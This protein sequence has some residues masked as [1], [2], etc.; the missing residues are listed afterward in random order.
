M[1]LSGRFISV[2]Q[3]APRSLNLHRL[4]EAHSHASCVSVGFA[5]LGLSHVSHIAVI[6]RHGVVVAVSGVG[7]EVDLGFHIGRRLGV[8]Y[9][10]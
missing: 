6:G 5:R 7:V 2:S 1:L 4:L 9:F 10:R 8:G 3:N